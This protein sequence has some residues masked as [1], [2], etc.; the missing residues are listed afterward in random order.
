MVEALGPTAT[1]PGPHSGGIAAEPVVTTGGAAPLPPT[2][3]APSSRLGGA[4][5]ELSARLGTTVAASRQQSAQLVWQAVTGF[6]V[7]VYCASLFLVHRP[8]SGYQSFWDGW[9]ANI[10]GTLP[11]I[12]I[13]LRIRH[14]TKLRAA[15]SAMAI[16]IALN[17]LANLVFL[18]HDQ[19]VHPLGSPAPSDIAYLL[20]DSAFIVGV[21]L[22]T[23]ASF[24]RGHLSIRLDGMVAGLA[25]GAAVAM[26]W[27]EPLLHVNGNPWQGAVRVAYPLC[28]LVLLVLVIAGLA[29]RRYRLTWSTGLL[30][31]GILWFV[32]GDVMYLNQASPHVVMEGRP[33]NGT[34]VIAIWLIGLSAWGREDR[35]TLP[36]RHSSVAPAGIALVPIVFGFLS[37]ALLALSL[38]R[39]DA[40]TAS[41]MALGAL[42]VVIARMALTLREL[43]RGAENFRDA[44]TDQLTALQNRRAFLE[45]AEVKLETARPPEHVGV[46]LVDLDGFKEINDSLGHHCGDELLRIVANRFQRK[47]ANRGSVARLGGDEFASACV[48]S[49]S[50][51]LVVVAQELAETLF[52][53]ISLDGV[54]VRVGASI[55]VSISPEHGTTHSDLLR[56]ADVAM[57]EAKRSRSIVCV[58]HP[59]HDL[60]SRERLEL[61]D[62]L[63]TAINSRSLTLHYQPTLNLHSE[64]V[65]GVEALVRWHHPKQGLLQPESFVPLAERVGLIPQLTRAVLEMA[66]DEAAHLEHGGHPL[67]MSVNISRYDLVDEELPEFIDALLELHD[68]PHSRLTL[69]VTESCIGSDPARARRSIDELRARGIR[70]SI[71][72]FGV[73]YSSMSQLLELPIDELKIDK[74][75]VLLLEE[76]DRA[77][78]IIS[79]TVELARALKLVVVAEGAERASNL[80]SLA[81][82]GVDIAQ[83]F[84]IARPLTAHELGQF[85]DRMTAVQAGALRA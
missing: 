47:I 22:M 10:A 52:D 17:G 14:K 35:R 79:S 71:D 20:S 23:Q 16:G 36:R 65:V 3:P 12:P 49:S 44:R 75:F 48:V 55:G 28:D 32:A 38:T 30:V 50:Q 21:A 37:L 53:P 80:N 84:H 2:V 72:D 42:G 39:H 9:V 81:Y 62:D 78:A 18:L 76:D 59:D 82:L 15:W 69:E 41:D 11:L 1:S 74:S 60:N 68:V 40:P 5:A 27:F 24:G 33:V 6:V 77:R 19:N 7:L 26:L 31:L 66:I 58:Y 83:G 61:I 29:P 13:Y 25:S 85:L 51:E 45:D 46:L 34:W 57:Y 4:M 73:G 8:T 43:R 67:Q 63:R 56:S 70:I 64:T 54:T